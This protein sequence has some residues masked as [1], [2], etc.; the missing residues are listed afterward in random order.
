MQYRVVIKASHPATGQRQECDRVIFA[1]S[2]AHALALGAALL[3]IDGTW[4][5]ERQTATPL[6]KAAANSV[7]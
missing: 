7:P 5:I 4:S 3:G 2:K 1:E 6:S